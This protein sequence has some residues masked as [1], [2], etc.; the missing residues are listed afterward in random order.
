MNR[1]LVVDDD[2]ALTRAINVRL[3]AEGFRVHICHDAHEASRA[4]VHQLPDLIILDVDLPGYSGMELHHCL[5]FSDRAKNIPVIYLSGYD[6]QTN[7]RVAFEQGAAAF[8]TKPYDPSVLVETI[9]T[10]IR[11]AQ[12]P[13]VPVE[14]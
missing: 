1:V 7:R 3:T 5:Q 9:R 2:R 10:T 14:S 13:Y 12:S 4:A 11:A 6:T 8:L